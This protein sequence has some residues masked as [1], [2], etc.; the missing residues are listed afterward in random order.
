MLNNISLLYYFVYILSLPFNGCLSAMYDT[1]PKSFMI[2]SG[3]NMNTNIG[4]SKNKKNC[5]QI[6]TFGFK[7]RNAKDFEAVSLLRMHNFHTLLTFYSH[8]Q[9]VTWHSFD[10]KNS[11]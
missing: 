9:K 2:T 11:A 5:N 10:G 6:G 1:I 8:K 4:I 3:P 7:N